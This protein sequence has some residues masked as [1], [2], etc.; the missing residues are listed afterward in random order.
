VTKPGSYVFVG[1]AHGRKVFTLEAHIAPGR[2]VLRVLA[3]ATE[4]VCSAPLASVVSARMTAAAPQIHVKSAAR[5]QLAPAKLA[6]SPVI[7]AISLEDAPASIRPF[8]FALLALAIV[9]LATAAAPQRLLPAGR[10][11]ALV[12]EQR[13][14]LAAAGIGLVVAVA[15]ATAFA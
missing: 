12:V 1:R 6:A 7:R 13:V 5:T 15:V 4:T 8:L 14:F 11:A 3:G 10:A 2:R 9:L